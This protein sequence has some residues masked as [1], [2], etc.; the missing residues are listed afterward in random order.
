VSKEKLLQAYDILSKKIGGN[1][2]KD[3]MV[4]IKVDIERR[5]CNISGKCEAC[6]RFVIKNFDD[7]TID[8][9]GDVT[10]PKAQL[11]SNVDSCNNVMISKNISDECF[12]YHYYSRGCYYASDITICPG[13]ADT[14]LSDI[15]N[16]GL[17][18]DES[19]EFCLKFSHKGLTA[20]CLRIISQDS[21]KKD[22]LD[23]A[24]NDIYLVAIC[25]LQNGEE[26]KG[27]S[28]KTIS[29]FS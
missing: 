20:N 4:I 17:S 25:N 2:I 23:F 14:W 7:F 6:P 10:L 21:S 27:F 3:R 8:P 9:S 13:Y 28:P 29:D 22:C 15:V 11:I 24:K 5:D 12:G 1:F 18:H 26:L 16:Y 19:K